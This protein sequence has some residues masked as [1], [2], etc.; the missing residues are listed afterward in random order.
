MEYVR[1][2]DGTILLSIE[3]RVALPGDNR[4]A[5]SPRAVTRCGAASGKRV[6]SGSC[7]HAFFR[8]KAQLRG[9]SATSLFFSFFSFFF[10]FPAALGYLT[11][12]REVFYFP[13][14]RSQALC[15]RILVVGVRARLQTIMLFVVKM[16]AEEY[17]TVNGDGPCNRGK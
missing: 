16:P 11:F 14:L 7:S 2:V 10:L 1:R 15:G 8:L 4:C 13:R 5:Q 3:C 6:C 9:C 12:P 17:A